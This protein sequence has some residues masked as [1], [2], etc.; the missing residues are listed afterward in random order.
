MNL[1]FLDTETT[2]LEPTRRL[3]QLAYKNPVS[4]VV[5]NE[6]FKPPMPISYGAMA[7]H[8]VTNEMVADKPEFGGGAVFNQLAQEIPTTVVVAHNAPFDIEVLKNEG[9]AVE[10][11]IDTLRLARHVIEAEQY[12]LQFLRYFLGLNVNGVNAHDALGDILVL[13]ALF[14]HLQKVVA[15]KF[16]LEGD[17]AIQK[18]IE[19]TN[20]PVLL[21]SFGF[22]KYRGKSF[23]EVAATDHG[24]L[25][26]LFGSESAKNPAEQNED[27]MV[28]LKHYCGK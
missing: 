5:V 20:T 1:I 14:N 21:K 13:E 10:K 25:D 12:N 24:Y 18:M 27:L 23:E 8:H 16:G 3:V 11:A 19:L 7:I 2:D 6:Y 15:E 9:I 4:G 22:G 28:T 17:G 26:W